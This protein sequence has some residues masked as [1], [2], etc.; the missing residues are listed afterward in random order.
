MFLWIVNVHKQIMFIRV[1]FTAD[2]QLCYVTTI[3]LA[4]VDN[5]DAVQFK[6]AGWSWADLGQIILQYNNTEPDETKKN[7]SICILFSGLYE[8]N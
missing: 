5:R 4:A 8:Q 1:Q 6:L 3:I 7:L 2:V